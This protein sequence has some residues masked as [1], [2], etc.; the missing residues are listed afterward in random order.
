MSEP[1]V[2]STIDA[3]VAMLTLLDAALLLVLRGYLGILILPRRDG[4]NSSQSQN[5]IPWG[6][7]KMPRLSAR[8]RAA[9]GAL[10][11]P[12]SQCQATD[13]G[14]FDVVGLVGRDQRVP[15]RAGFEGAQRHE[16]P[17]IHHA[18]KWET[19]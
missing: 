3:I 12:K 6:N 17:N 8:P 5:R 7:W 2:S 11:S 10:V 15:S 16:Y 4:P 18:V 9:G 14:G 1:V 13:F 19:W